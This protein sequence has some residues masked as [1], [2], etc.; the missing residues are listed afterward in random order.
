MTYRSDR[1]SDSARVGFRVVDCQAN[2]F[3]KSIIGVRTRFKRKGRVNN[4]LCLQ[5]ASIKST[6][7]IPG[8]SNMKELQ[9]SFPSRGS[10]MVG[11]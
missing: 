3:R 9:E 8:P 2:D 10:L 4:L 5:L 1:Q 7:M 6:K 11:S